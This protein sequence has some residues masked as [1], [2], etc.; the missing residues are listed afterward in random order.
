MTIELPTRLLSKRLIG[1]LL[2][3]AVLLVLGALVSC[4]APPRRVLS[5]LDVLSRQG[6]SPLRG[7]GVGLI[8]NHSAVDEG[9]RHLVD[10]VS[11]AEGVDLVAIFAPE[12][13]VRGLAEA[14]DKLGD[15]RDPRT[16]VP[17]YSLYGTVRKPTPA[18]LEGIDTLVFDIQDIGVRTYTYMSTLLACMEAAADSGIELWVLD[19]PNPL[20]GDVLEGPVLEEPFRSFVGPHRVPLRHGM[21]AGEFALMVNVERDI[22]ARLRVIPARGWRRQPVSPEDEGRWVA[23]SPNIP[24]PQTA[25][26]YAGFVLMEGTNLS[27]GRGTTRPFR[28][29][30]APWLDVETL[31]EGLQHRA[32]PGV[33]F[34]LT[35]FE[36]TFSKYAGEPCRGLEVHVLDPERF[37]PVE[38]A[39]TAIVEIRRL[40]PEQFEFRDSVWDRLAGADRVRQAIEAGQDPE[41]IVESWR[42]ELADFARRRRPFLIYPEAE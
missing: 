26:I 9:L 3:L 7:R 25:L 27:E 32:L 22:G 15:S 4:S 5:G 14:G 41:T 37:R 18:M 21:T 16:G 28:V 42:G 8:T 11:E 31:V 20:G 36:P 10:V 12:H 1:A 6:F 38:T 34:R 35:G 19:R 39:L 33:R 24:T 23:P 17:V 29:F 40:H 13:G 30:G 2:V